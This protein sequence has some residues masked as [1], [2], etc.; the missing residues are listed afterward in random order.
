MRLKN[1]LLFCCCILA[2]CQ[3]NG[4]EKPKEEPE[5]AADLW[6]RI[7]CER[8]V[9]VCDTLDALRFHKKTLRIEQAEDS[10]LQSEDVWLS[11]VVCCTSMGA[12]IDTL[13]A[14]NELIEEAI[15]KGAAFSRSTVIEGGITVRAYVSYS[16]FPDGK[17]MEG[18]QFGPDDLKYAWL[19]PFGEAFEDFKKDLET[20]RVQ[21]CLH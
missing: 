10:S 9:H 17:R 2:A 20:S 8:K 11:F 15:D 13:T 6:N 16:G 21:C 7:T 14:Y 12:L 19:C 1:F 4:N 18:L 5:E 3:D